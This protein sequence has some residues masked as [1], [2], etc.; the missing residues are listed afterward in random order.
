MFSEVG[1]SGLPVV[2]RRR[3]VSEQVLECGN[4]VGGFGDVEIKGLT[5]V[6]I[7]DGAFVG[8]G[9]GY[10]RVGSQPRVSPARTLRG[11]RLYPSL[12]SRR[13][14]VRTRR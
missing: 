2:E 3:D 5:S 14:G 8:F 13:A 4:Q 7:Q 1:D 10:C 11:R 9:R 12:P 6:L